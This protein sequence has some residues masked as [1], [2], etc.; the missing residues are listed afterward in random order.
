MDFLQVFMDDVLA[1]RTL[2]W[3]MATVM[4]CLA[5]YVLHSIISDWLRTGV[6]CICMFFGVL[7]GNTA[8][9]HLGVIISGNSET[10]IIATAGA[11]IC[12]MAT[13]FVVLAVIAGYFGDL[14]QKYKRYEGPSV[15]A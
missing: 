1:S 8:F 12:T 13:A 3:S 2:V 11:S 9:D 5:G 15:K 6:A 4:S 10:N 7:I 14:R